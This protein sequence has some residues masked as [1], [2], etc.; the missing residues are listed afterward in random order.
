MTTPRSDGR[1]PLLARQKFNVEALEELQE[2]MAIET[3]SSGHNA[4]SDELL[5]KYRMFLILLGALSAV[6]GLI[7]VFLLIK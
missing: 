7:V 4:Y 1:P 3:T 2:G 6:L 5:A